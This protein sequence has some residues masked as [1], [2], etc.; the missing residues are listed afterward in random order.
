MAA[1]TARLIRKGNRDGAY[2]QHVILPRLII[3]QT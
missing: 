3:R 1:Q 2:E